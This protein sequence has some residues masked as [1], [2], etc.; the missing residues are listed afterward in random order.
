MSTNVQALF[1]NGLT[2]APIST[3]AVAVLYIVVA[4]LTN[5]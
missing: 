3:K 1:C 5:C 4:V 2:Y